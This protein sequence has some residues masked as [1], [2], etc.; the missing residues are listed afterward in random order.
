MTEPTQNG[1]GDPARPVG[2]PVPA[3]PPAD[4][5]SAPFGNAIPGGG[6]PSD[7]AAGA[8]WDAALDHAMD[9]F[10]RDDAA[11]DRSGGVNG[12]GDGS[13]DQHGRSRARLRAA[14][15]TMTGRMMSERA[16]RAS[17][18]A[19]AAATA[20]AQAAQAA[21]AG[22]SGTKEPPRR[23]AFHW[24]FFGG[25]GVLIAYVTYLVLD[26]IRD[27]LILIAIAMLLA[28][29]LDPLVNLITKRGMRRGSGVAIVF[30]GLLVV[31]GA[32]IY[33]IIPPIVNEVGSFAATVPQLITDLQNNSSIR[34][35]DTKFGI[36]NAIRNS[37]IVQTL[38]SGAASGLLTATATVASVA[39]DLLIILV[40][41][42]YLLSGF[43]KIK[44]AGYRLVPAS[45]RV[46]VSDLGDRVL[47]QMGG[48]LSGATII[49]IQAGL[50][51]GTFAAI[52][53]LP[54]PWAIGLAA[55]VLDFIPVV[56]PI[57]VGVGMTLIGFTQGVAI[58]I[59]AGV[60]YLLQHMFEAYW[61]YPRVMRRTVDIST[62]AVV[63]AILIGA[64]L[65][66]VTG[67]IL[68][69]PVAAAIMLIVREVI[70]P[71]QEGS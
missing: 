69:V 56:G 57:T 51:A 47:K 46:R 38:G 61:L 55:A 49:A 42:L 7:D 11:G 62:G 25:F 71:M 34:D 2:R 65:L 53:G 41:T 45:R 4:V 58:G 27:T 19:A 59:I 50:V 31:I 6:V 23:S 16:V 39:L 54:Y 44:A 15:S 52:I 18:A 17:E 10:D 43:P 1:A 3:G 20:S 36:L 30:I 12:A 5:G 37:N 21:A 70:M 26:T 40:L 68:A 28:I 24:G 60:F 64:A 8:E 32:A 22:Q 29:G 14:V 48:Y 63:V 66:G 33:A 35:L 67:A 13:T 9:E